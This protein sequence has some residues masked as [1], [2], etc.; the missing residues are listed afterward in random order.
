MTELQEYIQAFDK[1]ELNG[2]FKDT[3]LNL[4]GKDCSDKQLKQAFIE[5]NLSK[6]DAV[7][8][9]LFSEFKKLVIN[10]SD[11]DNTALAEYQSLK[12]YL[13]GHLIGAI[14][15]RNS[16]S[17][18]QHLRDLE[19]RITDFLIDYTLSSRI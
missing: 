10:V 11:N 19:P 6:A 15:D 16:D 5:N 4:I 1:V 18:N 17:F 7:L 2:F 13:Y 9:D 12:H 14:E 3:I 8:T